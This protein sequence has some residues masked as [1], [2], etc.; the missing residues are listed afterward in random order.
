MTTE[1]KMGKRVVLISD[2]KPEYGRIA[3]V[4]LEWR[5]GTPTPVATLELGNGTYHD[6]DASA[7]FSTKEVDE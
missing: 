5:Q 4:R 2:G 7:I 6:C 3:D 1:L